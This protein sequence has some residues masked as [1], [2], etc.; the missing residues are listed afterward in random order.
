MRLSCT[1]AVLAVMLCNACAA[2]SFSP[3]ITSQDPGIADAVQQGRGATCG[4][5]EVSRYNPQGRADAALN[6][7]LQLQLELQDGLTTLLIDVADAD[8]TTTVTLDVRY[9]ASHLHPLRA[10][11][12]GLLGGS[13]QTLSAAYFS[14]PGVASIGQTRVGRHNRRPLHGRFATLYFAS[15]PATRAT[16]ASGD[17][18]H[19]PRGVGDSIQYG[20]VELSN[21]TASMS[22][23]CYG[24]ARLI[25]YGAWHRGD[26]DQNGEVNI[27]DITPVGDFFGESS[28]D[29]CAAARA[30]YDGN[31]EVNL[32]D[33]TIIGQHLGESTQGYSIGISD[34]EDN[35]PPA[36]ID[37]VAW[38]DG[39]Q[40]NSASA[41]PGELYPAFTR[42]EYLISGLEPTLISFEDLYALDTNEDFS[43]R[44]HVMPFTDRS[45]QID[46]ASAYVDCHFPIYVPDEIDVEGFTIRAA[47]AAGG[48][49]L[50]NDL[51]VS[52]LPGLLQA[53]ANQSLTLTL[54]SISGTFNAQWFDGHDAAALPLVLDPDL[55]WLACE[56]VRERLQWTA[57][58]AGA[59]GFRRSD[60][61]LSTA[62]GPVA[63]PGD[64]GA[65]TVFPDDDPQSV[66]AQAE[67]SLWLELPA[68]DEW[69][70]N[71]LDGT[72]LRALQPISC[73]V[74]GDIAAD[75]AA[76]VLLGYFDQ[77]GQPLSGLAIPLDNAV[78]ICLDWGTIPL[79][80]EQWEDCQLELRGVT[81]GLADASPLIFSY[82]T[83][84][85]LEPGQ[86]CIRE[87]TEPEAM[88]AIDCVVPG[89][90][91]EF[92][93]D[94]LFRVNAGG[95]WSSVNKPD[96]LL[97]VYMP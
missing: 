5:F 8:L 9:D 46:G 39:Q 40:F 38:E 16:S 60:D 54:D 43:I 34:N 79:P 48:V 59:T 26:G 55:Y 20:D 89:L 74:L 65:C 77:A 69:I 95:G 19:N 44:F 70:Y 82:S 6:S 33:L 11:F 67:G 32:A 29:N 85:P 64:P 15:G 86:F 3:A 41:V 91:L 61:W 88:F 53:Q 30:D 24:E 73:T 21:F 52:D 35:Q 75:P 83:T 36:W 1:E 17:A 45:T 50:D 58:H 81:L 66:G 7:T 97:A 71:D 28:Y 63:G 23:G 27:A 93:H 22:F 37:T 51:F 49:G 42:W 94:Y 76:P 25:W 96:A 47:G 68:L 84:L 87:L 72:R 80:Q 12:A 90:Q 13:E 10:Q 4:D 31:T 62:S 18:H 78:R 56:R 14:R 57:M 2:G 92:E